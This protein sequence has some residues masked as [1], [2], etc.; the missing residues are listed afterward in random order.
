MFNDSDNK[1]SPSV[2]WKGVFTVF[3]DDNIDENS[4]SMNAKTN[5]HQTATTVLQFPTAQN[6]GQR[7]LRNTFSELT[8]GEKLDNRDFQVLFKFKKLRLQI[9]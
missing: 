7:R 8:D 1:V 9:R 2:M 6:P 3:V 5:F 4:S